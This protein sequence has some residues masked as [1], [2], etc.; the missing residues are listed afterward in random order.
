MDTPYRD[1]MPSTANDDVPDFGNRRRPAREVAGL[2]LRVVPFA[3]ILAGE[4]TAQMAA[5]CAIN[6]AALLFALVIVL[7]EPR[8]RA[9]LEARH[10]RA[11]VKGVAALEAKVSARE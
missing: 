4:R 10:L 9:A 3:A 2:A 1:V 5:F 11:V 7:L 8:V 6:V